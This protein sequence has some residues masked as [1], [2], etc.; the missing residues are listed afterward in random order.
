MTDFQQA[1]RLLAGAQAMMLPVG[2][3]DLTVTGNQIEAVLWFAFSAGFVIRAIC[4]TGD[5]RRLAVILALAFLVFGISD[6]IEAQTGAW[7]R[8][9]WLLLLKSACIAVFAYGLWEHLR[10]RRRDRDAAGSP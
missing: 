6:L 3:D 1:T 7:W 9:L 2:M 10:L 4:T 5:H 8:P